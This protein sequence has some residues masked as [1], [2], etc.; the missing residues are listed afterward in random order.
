MPIDFALP[1]TP[2]HFVARLL[3]HLPEGGHPAKAPVTAVDI[4][5]ELGVQSQPSVH[6]LAQAAADCAVEEGTTTIPIVKATSARCQGL[7]QA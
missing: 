3:R 7:S 1:R 5:L 4:E 2:W 6:W